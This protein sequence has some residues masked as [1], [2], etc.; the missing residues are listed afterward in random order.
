MMNASLREKIS[1]FLTTIRSPDHIYEFFKLLNYPEKVLLDSSFK[2]KIEEFDFKK[3]DRDKIKNIYTVLNFEKNLVVFIVETTSLASSLIKS[4]SKV[5]SD[6]YENFLLII[7]PDYYTFYFVFPEFEKVAVGRYKLKITKL[8]IQRDDPYYTGIEVLSNLYYEGN[9][10]TW[11]DVYKKWKDAFSVEKVTEKFFEYYKRIFF[12]LREEIKKQGISQK[13]AHEFTLQLLNRIMFIYFV[14][15]KRWLNNDMHFMKTFWNSYKSERNKGT[16]R[17]DSFYDVWLRNLFFKAFNNRQNEIKDLPEYWIKVFYTFPY[18]NGGLFLEKRLDSL[19]IVLKDSL[20]SEIFEFFNKYNFT[21]KEDMPLEQEVAV[22]PAMIGY[23]YESLANVAEEIYD[24]TDLGIFYTPRVEVDFMCRR[25]L[26]EY[27][28]KHLPEVPKDKLYEL[29][30]D[31]DK[32]KSE[33]Y[34]SKLNIWHRLEEVLND[35]SVVDPACGSGSFLIGMMNVLFELYKVI[36]KNLGRKFRAFDIKSSII[37]GS[38]FGVDVMPW[39]VHAAELRLWLQLIIETEFTKEQLKKQPLLPN[40]NLNLRVGDSLVQEIGGMLFNIQSKD[41][42][43]RI[44]KKLFNLKKEK[45]S[46]YNNQPSRFYTREEILEEEIRIFDELV[47]ERINLIKQDLPKFEKELKNLEEGKQKDLTGKKIKAP[48]EEINRAKERLEKARR[49]LENLY[50]IKENLKDALK[51]PEKKPFVWEID[52][53]E[54]FGDKGGF[55]IVIGNP[56]YVRQEKISPPNKIK[57]EVTLEDRREYKEK[58]IQSVKLKFPVVT[59]IDRKSDYYIYFYFHGLSLLN[60]NGIFC[61]IT[62]NSWLD[63]DYGKELQEFL[64]KYTPII[65]I[66]DNPKRSFEHAD[67]NTIIALFGA[68]LLEENNILGLKVYGNNKWPALSNIAKFVMFKK[69]FEE[70]ISSKNLIDIENIKIKTKGRG[71]TELVKNVVKTDDYRCFPITQEDLL[72]DGWEYPENYDEKKGRFKAGS[73]EGNKWGGKF[74]RAPDIFY[75]ILEKGK[76]KL[77]ELG[78]IAKV[79]TGCYSGIDDFF[80]FLRK[81]KTKVEKEFIKKIITSPKQIENILIDANKIKT[82]IFACN[83]S[84]NELKKYPQALNYILWGEKQVTRKHMK[85][86]A[87]IPFPKVESVKNRK[88]GWWIIPENN[89]ISVNN[90]LPLS[91][92][93]RFYSPFSEEPLVSDRCFHRLIPNKDIDKLKLAFS[94]N[95]SI[96]FLIMEILGNRNLG[97][98]ALDFGT[99]DAKKLLILNPKIIKNLSA[100]KLNYTIKSIFEELGI[101]PSKPIREQEP[102]PLPDRAELDKIVFDEL[103]LTKDE[104]KEVYWSVCE[105]V[106]QRLD[107]ARSLRE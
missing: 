99:D 92:S 54:I 72:E 2:R 75:T 95:N 22:D 44:K 74:L 59:N 71:I 7:T 73:Y 43:D 84:K 102:K 57:A 10:K 78:K 21:I 46:Y 62:S 103:G 20:F 87:G 80:Y 24:R 28:A 48:E 17:P 96:S 25:S 64:L 42:S 38:L 91:I 81:P 60:K 104:R 18:L 30:F 94:L 101:D 26:V 23:V 77:I 79:K 93:D 86:P 88:N 76:G 16:V 1:E 98:G 70:V 8:F 69:P 45:E 27:L 5:F 14:S 13:D 55:D 32:E 15:K 89:I 67:I 97:L 36:Y 53:A 105:L 19:K 65:A 35:L 50:K 51:H 52:F 58:L 82:K 12:E 66:Y 85:T 33:K 31:E 29:V 4:I 100:S 3:E 61:F 90:F 106:K 11:R 34:F 40:F 9:E 63:V 68:P 41:L 37:R 107:K 83:K 6:K 56:P 39:A 47:E 49:E